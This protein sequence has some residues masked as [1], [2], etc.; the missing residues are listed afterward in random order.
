MPPGK[1]SAQAG[2]AYTDTL[3]QAQKTDPSL[4]ADYRD[5]GKGGSKVTLRSKTLH[6]LL[7]AYNE[8]RDLGIPCTVVVDQNHI[9]PPHFNGDPIITAI[10]V[11]PCTQDQVRHILKRFNCVK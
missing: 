7:R 2:H 9:L 11:G 10:G 5:R 3:L 1:L 8:I 4:V 6:K